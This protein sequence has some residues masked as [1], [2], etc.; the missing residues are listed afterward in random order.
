MST[1]V[2]L[3][4]STGFV[5]RACRTRLAEAGIDTVVT[6]RSSD[7]LGEAAA[8]ERL[9]AMD[10]TEAASIDAVLREYRPTHLLHLAWRAVS[11]DIWRSPENYAWYRHSV[12]LMTAF[13]RA[14]GRRV[15]G[16]GTC[17]EYDWSTG[18]CDETATPEFPNTAYGRAKLATR[19]AAAAL[20]DAYDVT[21][22]W[23]RVFFVYGPG[24]ASARLL[25]TVVNNLLAGR[26]AEVSHGRQLRDYMHVADVAGGLV[27]LLGSDVVGP[28][29]VATG[30][31]IRVRDLVAEAAE[32]IGRP[33]F[34]QWGAK[35]TG[36]HEPPLIV[37]RN[38]RLID[39]VGYKPTMNLSAGV[40]DVIERARMAL[41]A[42]SPAPTKAS[43]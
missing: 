34:V 29:N 16:C 17:G 40:A 6:G 24:E 33:E 32:Q 35:P 8:S 19:H 7:G 22:A 23:G 25:P 4:G 31:A 10:V 11:G 38:R 37:A 21:T 15:V 42:P 14:G 18:M 5:G 3:T 9:V 26:P 39:E 28:V 41:D 1:R 43:A 36:A 2:L 30:E 20:T 27:A 13:A 12:A